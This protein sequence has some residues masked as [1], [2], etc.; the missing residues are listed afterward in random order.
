M[1]N[2]PLPGS[3]APHPRGGDPHPG[4]PRPEGVSWDADLSLHKRGQSQADRDES[5]TPPESLPSGQRG[6]SMSGCLAQ[7]KLLGPQELFPSLTPTPTPYLVESTTA[8]WSQLS[9]ISPENPTGGAGRG[10][11]RWLS[12]AKWEGGGS[13]NTKGQ[14]AAAPLLGWATWRPQLWALGHGWGYCGVGCK[15]DSFSGFLLPED[16]PVSLSLFPPPQ[17]LRTLQLTKSLVACLCQHPL[18]PLCRVPFC[19]KP[20]FLPQKWGGVAVYP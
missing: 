6:L 12:L 11:P 16:S 3:F 8:C 17:S 15:A 13:R 20:P 7:G 2:V 4:L 19:P 5:V 9:P 1:Q 10:G 14:A 18:K